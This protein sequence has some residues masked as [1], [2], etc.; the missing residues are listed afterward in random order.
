MELL[1]KLC[2]IHAPSGEEVNISKFLI[3]YIEENKKSWKSKPKIYFGDISLDIPSDFDLN[4]FERIN[5]LFNKVLL[6]YELFIFIT[7]T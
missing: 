3:N 2:S 1:K 5:N 6:A 4:N 7:N